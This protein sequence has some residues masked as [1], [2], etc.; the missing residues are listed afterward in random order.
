MNIVAL[1][2]LPPSHRYEEVA[3]HLSQSNLVAHY[4]TITR[5]EKGK[6][7]ERDIVVFAKSDQPAYRLAQIQ[8]THILTY[9]G[10]TFMVVPE[11]ELEQV[12]SFC[13]PFIQ[14]NSIFTLAPDLPA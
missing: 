8:L 6:R 11:M 13:K 10:G 14:K 4:A 9:P 5:V 3:K 1:L 2:I 12:R 7:E